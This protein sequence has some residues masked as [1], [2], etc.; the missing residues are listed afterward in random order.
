[1]S[2][3]SSVDPGSKLYR[4]RM[5]IGGN[6]DTTIDFGHAYPIL[7][8][9]V[10]PGDVIK[11]GAR[12]FARYQPTL[13][14]ILNGCQIRMRYFFV[15]HRQVIENIADIITGT[16]DG[17][18]LEEI[19]ECPNFVADVTNDNNY[20]VIKGSFWDY[21][22][23]PC[24]NYKAIKNDKC[25]PA[26]YW[27]KAYMKIYYDYFRDENLSD[28][29]DFETTWENNLKHLGGHSWL[30]SVNLPKDY[31]T[32][33]TPF[34]LKGE[35]PTFDIEITEP[36]E[37]DFVYASLHDN[38]EE[39][40]NPS[41]YYLEQTLYH[42]TNP[43]TNPNG[44][45][46]RATGA[47]PKGQ[48]YV[49]IPQRETYP[50]TI[51][52]SVGLYGGEL[53]ELFNGVAGS[54][55][56]R[57]LRTMT[58]LTRIKE[59]EMRC[60]SRYTEYLRSN[61]HTAPADETLQRPVYLGGFKQ[62]IL[63]NEIAQTAADGDTPVGTLRGKGIT[64][65]GQNIKPYKAKE[66]GM[67]FGILD[68]V[69]E[70]LYTQGINRELTYKAR[71]DFFNPSFQNLSEQEVRNGEI[72]ISNSDGKNDAT[73]GFQGM[74]NELRSKRNI[75]TSELRDNLK[76]WTQAIEFASRPNL[77]SHFVKADSYLSSFKRP[78]SIQS[79]ANPII[80][81]VENYVDAYR[82]MVRNPVPGLVDH[83]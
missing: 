62:P 21:L 47:S 78:F 65:G 56:T 74:Y 3:Y 50:E 13:A 57:D 30:F 63:S 70:I 66:F 11:C 52:A 32:S 7:A 23:V 40:L 44:N 81:H 12:I 42:D 67:L 34:E 39:H 43:Q 8:K 58:Q 6:H 24:L 80:L 64:D 4:S 31:F 16:H 48:G 25:L 82:P 45:I 33:A 36:F 79:G 5:N 17:R 10:L 28:I 19:P 83:N 76:Y 1:M 46:Y 35:V 60:G 37:N 38:D 18:V 54:F 41:N 68:V 49:T 26:Q 77:N 29:S 15:N 9:F 27:Y 22:G 20:N 71:Y 72:F 75:V 2:I 69:P 73:F 53:N 59:R 55:S 51:E 61:F 14:P